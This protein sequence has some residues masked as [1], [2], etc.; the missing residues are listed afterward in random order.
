MTETSARLVPV[1]RESLDEAGKLVQAGGLVAYP[2][3]TVYGL[4][5][6][7]F[8]SAAVQRLVDAKQRPKGALPVLVNSMS[9]ARRIGDFNK[10]A[11]KLA[12]DFWPGGLTIIVPIKEKMPPRVTDGTQFIGLRIPRH[13]TALNL[14]ENCKGQIIGTSA[15]VS[16]HPS[17]RTADAVF[18]ELGARI[19]LILDGG[20]T[21]I[22]KDSTIV[23]VIG[24]KID[25]LREGAVSRDELLKSLKTV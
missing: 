1:N 24:G 22:G 7:P 9:V 4:G 11:T 12:G 15:N 25:V 20:P 5:C 2:T 23:K 18:K 8:N 3:D 13:E 14:I 16:G 17:P 10:V 19:D 6:N 21:P